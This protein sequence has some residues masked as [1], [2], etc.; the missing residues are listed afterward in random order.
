MATLS[1]V[2]R[3]AGVSLSTASRALNGSRDRTVRPELAA[4]A[5]QAAR[6][7]DYVPNAAA[8][9]MARGHSMA[10]ALIVNDIRDPYFSSI[11]AG[12]MKT[13][14]ESGYIVTLST[15]SYDRTALVPLINV[16]RQQRPEALLIAGSLWNEEAYL[17]QVREALQ[18]FQA[19]T[20]SQVCSIGATQLGFHCV[21]VKNRVGA[22]GLGAALA[23]QG[24]ETAAVLAGPQLHTTA[25][26]RTQGFREGFSESGTVVAEVHGEFTR[27]GGYEAMMAVLGMDRL[28]QLV[29]A[30]NDVMA[31][32]ALAAAR[33]SGV[34]VPD[35]IAVAGFDDIPTLRDITPSLT[36][37]RVPMELLGTTA[38]NLALTP[39]GTDPTTVTLTTTPVFRDSTALV[40][41]L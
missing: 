40:R 19:S 1:D 10:I 38:V 7:L 2:A 12:V 31:V 36:T 39:P 5:L 32:G 20:E 21:T 24:F 18:E 15:I 16:M 4:K 41:N 23:G 26:K 6:E 28:P 13:A 33:E 9:T 30:V 22:Q 25:T 3:R 29:F 17:D 37:V 8:Q 34:R 11:A 27:D 14:S 35:Q